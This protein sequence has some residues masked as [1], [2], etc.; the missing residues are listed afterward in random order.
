MKQIKVL[1]LGLFFLQTS[2]FAQFDILKDGRN[3]DLLVNALDKLY[4]HEFAEAESLLV[5]V[6]KKFPTHPAYHMLMAM[7]YNMQMVTVNKGHKHF[8]EYVK[9]LEMVVKTSQPML[10]YPN[11]KPE[12]CFFLIGAHSS[13]AYIKTEEKDYPGVLSQARLS[14]KYIKEGFAYKDKYPDF[15]FSTGLFNFYVVQYPETHP[16]AKPLMWFFASGN[17]QYGIKEIEKGAEIGTFS[18]TESIAFAAHVHLKYENTPLHALNYTTKLLKQFPNNLFYR[19]RHIESLVFSNNYDKVKIHIK[20]LY[21]NEHPIF[22]LTAQL[23]S[24]MVEENEMHLN[25]ALEHYEKC[26]EIAT[27]YNLLNSDYVE[28][29]YWRLAKVYEQKNDKT[30]ANEFYKKTANMAE[31]NIVKQDIKKYYESRSSTK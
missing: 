12:A 5:V 15:H 21:K 26:I 4:N 13:L 2:V 11:T 28:L 30:K 16:M 6:K 9:E 31:Y 17:K 23:F 20:E 10:E 24:G 7:K 22:K 14:Y 3:K 27:K 1:I 8:S 18:K 25:L 19:V 29:T